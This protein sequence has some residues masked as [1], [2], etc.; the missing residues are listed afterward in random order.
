MTQEELGGGGWR[1]VDMALV[2][3]KPQGK[4]AFLSRTLQSPP[5]KMHLKGSKK[6]SWP[7]PG[8]LALA[9]GTAFR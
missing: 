2:P 8:A 7:S 3:H 9:Q 1:G 6:K 4:G 5:S